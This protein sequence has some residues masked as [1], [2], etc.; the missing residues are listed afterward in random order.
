LPD[1]FRYA[2]FRPFG[3]NLGLPVNLARVPVSRRPAARKE[4]VL[5]RLSSTIH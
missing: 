5:E 2:S 3:V 4:I 1:L